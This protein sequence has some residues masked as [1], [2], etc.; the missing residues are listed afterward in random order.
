MLR[1]YWDYKG[2]FGNENY[3]QENWNY[4]LQ[5]EINK[6]SARIHKKLNNGGA[7]RIHVSPKL[8]KLLETLQYFQLKYE[9]LSGEYDGTLSGRFIIYIK[10][11]ISDN[12]IIVFNKDFDTDLETIEVVNYESKKHPLLVVINSMEVKTCVNPSDIKKTESLIVSDNNKKID[13][14]YLNLI[15]YARFNMCEITKLIK[16]NLDNCIITRLPICKY[17]DKVYGMSNHHSIDEI[18][19][20]LLKNGKVII[21]N[22]K[23]ETERKTGKIT[24]FV[25]CELI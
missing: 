24:F 13:Q 5:T 19:T 10:K 12:E 3:D 20:H 2:W 15:E 11:N 17:E 16:D 23:H 8:F 22:A 4:T 6:A 25:R 9:T 1:K 14:L 7:D 21:Y 18:K